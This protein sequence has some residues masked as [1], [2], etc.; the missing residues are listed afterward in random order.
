[1]GVLPLYPAVSTEFSTQLQSYLHREGENCLAPSETAALSTRSFIV[2]H[3]PCTLLVILNAL[4]LSS[5]A[6]GLP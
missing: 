2:N 6:L 4:K 1:M 5:F 3:S